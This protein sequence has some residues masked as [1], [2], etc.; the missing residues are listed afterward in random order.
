MIWGEYSWFVV[1]ID[2]TIEGHSYSNLKHVLQDFKNLY[3][4]LFKTG[5]DTLQVHF[6]QGGG[7]YASK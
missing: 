3:V 6:N 7:L 2:K 1:P 4:T 5:F